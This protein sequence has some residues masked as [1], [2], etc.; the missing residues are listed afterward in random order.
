[1][2][3]E[4]I[5]EK[6]IDPKG[7]NTVT[8]DNTEVA[9]TE[10]DTNVDTDVEVD[11]KIE[12][13]P[14][15]ESNVDKTPKPKFTRVSDIEIA[16]AP[17]F[18]DPRTATQS[19]A[20]IEDITQRSV[21]PGAGD[22]KGFTGLIDTQAL[23][24]AYAPMDLAE[25]IP[26]AAER[27]KF[28]A[29]HGEKL[30]NLVDENI[31]GVRFQK[32]LE[33]VYTFKEKQYPL[34]VKRFIDE[35]DENQSWYT[36]SALTLGK[37]VGKTGLAVAGG[38]VGSVYG[39]VSAL[40]NWDKDKFFDNSFF[41]A[42]EYLDEGLDK[43]LAIYGGS[44]VWDLELNPDTQKLEFKQKGFFSRFG[45]DP[46]KSLNQDVVPAVS[47]IAGAVISELTAAAI[48]A[49]TGGLGVGLLAANSARVTNNVLN[50]GARATKFSKAN[51]ILRGLDSVSDLK[52]K[53]NIEALTKA[54]RAGL[55]TITSGYR[56]SAYES[57]LIARD[58]KE[59]ALDQMLIRHHEKMGGTITADGR[60]LDKDGN[61][62][63]E[64][65]APSAIQLEEY[66]QAASDAGESAYFM[67]VPL[68]AGAN[69]IQMP[70]LF[71]KN[72]RVASA[73]RQGIK[74]KKGI[75]D[76]FRLTGTRIVD[77]KRVA[78]VDADKFLKT[79]GYSKAILKGPITEG[80]EEFAQGA[81]QEGLV[82]YYADN[83]SKGASRS[84]TGMLSAI[85]NK[86]S[87]YANTTEG[88]DSM[89]IGAIMGLLGL[90]VPVFTRSKTSKLGFSLSSKSFG[91]SRQEYLEAKR[92]MET[93]RQNAEYLN[94]EG[95]INPMLRA[96][97]ENS[98]RHKA[99][100]EGMDDAVEANNTYEFKNKEH[101][102]LFSGVYNRVKLGL[103]DT[104][105]Q[106][107]EAL[108]DL[109]LDVFNEQFGTKGV[110]EFTEETK[111]EAIE[112]A[113][114]NVASMMD[115][116]Q[117]VEQLLTSVK[118]DLIQNVISGVAEAFKKTPDTLP[119]N[120]EFINAGMREQMAYLNAAVQNTVQ[121]EKEL[122]QQIQD[123]TG[124]SLNI[125]NLDKIVAQIVGVNLNSGKVEFTNRANEVKKEILKEYKENDPVGY[126]MNI[127]KIEPLIDD[128]LKLKIRRGE[129][130]KMY[131]GLFTPKGAKMF[132]GFQVALEKA[133]QKEND[134]NLRKII[135]EKV[136]NS[137]NASL[138]RIAKNEA[139]FNKGA[140]PAVDERVTQDTISGLKKIDNIKSRNLPIEEELEAIMNVLDEEPG[141]LT[142]VKTRLQEKGVPLTGIKTAKEILLGDTEGNLIAPILAEIDAIT[143]EASLR[144]DL[145]T[146]FNAERVDQLNQSMATP[147]VPTKEEIK[148]S[149]EEGLFKFKGEANNYFTI[150]NS[151]QY[152]IKNGK[153]VLDDK[154]KPKKHFL[155]KEKNYP[156]NDK[157]INDPDFLPNALLDDDSNPQYF[158][159]KI[160][161][162]NYNKQEERSSDK[163]AIDVVHIDSKTG[164]ETF[165]SR[166][167]SVYENSPQQLKN[168]REEIVRRDKT[169]ED[170]TVEERANRIQEIKKEKEVI[171]KKLQE[172]LD[173]KKEAPVAE[174]TQP[175]AE[176]TEEEFKEFTDNATV[177]DARIN[178]IVNKI[179]AGTE[180][181]TQEQAM[182]EE[183][184]EQVEKA[185]KEDTTTEL[186]TEQTE[187]KSQLNDLNKELKDLA[188]DIKVT[189][190]EKEESIFDKISDLSAIK[191][192]KRKQ[193]KE[194]EI[195][196]DFGKENIERANAINNNFQDIV[197]AIQT[198]GIQIFLNPETKK[199]ENC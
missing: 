74:G 175:I 32:D 132:A 60:I 197:T 149:I 36:E 86:A 136:E 190:I 161:D 141:L 152:E 193:E 31:V 67:N 81:M 46:L 12:E 49:G 198:S 38:L 151:R 54:Y 119:L 96:N 138:E 188:G 39:A 57:A 69:F 62:L 33:D 191:S 194:N 44:D 120:K 117:D 47:F 79:L 2:A 80:F 53:A 15:L 97:F 85:S 103:G 78:N 11:I 42:T 115:S 106:D 82:D 164:E 87:A 19:D 10:V 59:S 17:E 118:P 29:Y 105:I 111:K 68:V 76:D 153:V 26:D 166:L 4:L 75:F 1:M 52:N 104:V 134:E 90:R 107:I 159:F 160:S 168:L 3:E 181:T 137:K 21:T 83:Y 170:T 71:T 9:D 48:T 129:A 27:E 123:I 148:D 63:K 110:Q 196:K 167:P 108:E 89:A 178:S 50:W 146:G 172:N 199:H 5:E 24:D 183:K 101:Q 35:L 142:L 147:G 154:G 16:E 177:S 174:T 72:Y 65:I 135:E 128:I 127:A 37:L 100:Q 143:L 169:A 179:K 88:Q 157:K 185:L 121:R 171:K 70:R 165:I 116:I 184:A 14:K 122:T 125:N 95:N 61:Q 7:I 150:I 41:D 112:K 156:A 192:K 91:G 124:S 158:E 140:T 58:T 94:N 18:A 43:H 187:L 73:A 131:E 8:G 93:A 77:G 189:F 92:K 99:T 66:E 133:Q 34:A 56:S 176:V 98:T 126:S 13:P 51:R 113:K 25:G 23:E 114:R 162:N 173:A 195:E 28:K 30:V 6:P 180:L 186:D 20:I 22:I 84:I 64:M 109:S 182:R 102:Q 155:S 144:E 145:D 139:G 45:N 55:G 163:I 40:F 130:A